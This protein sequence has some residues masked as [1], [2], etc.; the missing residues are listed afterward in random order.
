MSGRMRSVNVKLHRMALHAA[1]LEYSVVLTRSDLISPFTD[2]SVLHTPLLDQE[3]I[4][5]LSRSLYIILDQQIPWNKLSH[6]FSL[7]LHNT[8]DWLQFLHY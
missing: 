8:N 3:S 5:P 6:I 1:R 7:C 2:M 4:H